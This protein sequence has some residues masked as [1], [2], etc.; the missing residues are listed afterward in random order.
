M[1]EALI[2]SVAE[3][4]EAADVGYN[5]R[6][7]KLID[8]ISEYTLTYSDG[9]EHVFEDINDGYRHIRDRKFRAKAVAAIGAGMS[10]QSIETAP[11]DGTT[12]LVGHSESVFSAWWEPDGWKTGS[13]VAGWVDGCTNNDGDYSTYEP[14]H[15]QPLPPPP[16]TESHDGVPPSAP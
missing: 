12:I 11:R 10:W 16:N 5:L 2:Q 14:T 8:G 1:D 13:G 4:I 7:T 3:A 15:W 6:L 9:E